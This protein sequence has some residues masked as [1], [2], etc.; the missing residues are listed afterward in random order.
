M[1]MRYIV[2]LTEGAQQDLAEM[3]GFVRDKDG[4]LAAT[5]MLSEMVLILEGLSPNPERGERPADLEELG[6]RGN[7]LITCG[8]YRILYR[9]NSR[10]I[11]VLV[12]SDR[13]RNMREKLERRL[14]AARRDTD[15]SREKQYPD[16]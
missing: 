4:P 2:L 6:I 16:L 3:V 15:S 8:L 13:R 5:N 14:I 7:R 11:F 10:D 9:F 1:L 12:L